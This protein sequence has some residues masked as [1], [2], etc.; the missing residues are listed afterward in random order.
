[1]KIYEGTDG[2][3]GLVRKLIE[4]YNFKKVVYEGDNASID[5]QD[6]IFQLWVTD[7]LFL[8]GQFA[9]TSMNFGW[10]DLRT[11]ALTCPCIARSNYAS[12]KRRWIIYKQ[13]DLVAI[14]I[15]EDRASRPGINIIIGE[16]INYETGETGIGMTTS[17]ANNLISK[18]AVFT[19][20]MSVLSTP[21]R[22]YCQQKSVTSLAPVVSASQN[23]GFTNVYH[24]L[25]HIQGITDG[26]ND[27]NYTVPTQ[28]ILLNNK[29]YLLSRFAF[30]IKD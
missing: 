14:G 9:D 28:T 2:L 17:S 4:V 21:Y 13:T 11:E 3:R 18:Y 5:T 15:D 23:K 24:I 27:N 7:E 26:S 19:N 30:E 29:K 1:M 12:D 10:C 22:Y 20:G 25:S 6:A 8:R 16:I